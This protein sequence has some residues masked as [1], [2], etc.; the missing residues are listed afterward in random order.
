M[1]DLALLGVF[2]HPDDEELMGGVYAQS[3]AGGMSTGL[4]CATRGELGEITEPA[5]ATPDNLG[6]VREQDL[7][8]ACAV[9]GI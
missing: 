2:A 6:E 8:A 3:A 5:L 1:A 4:I 9:L 7:R